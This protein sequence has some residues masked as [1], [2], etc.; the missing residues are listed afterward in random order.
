MYTPG[1][2]R[3]ISNSNLST[4]AAPDSK[5]FLMQTG[6][7]ENISLTPQK[8]SQP[9]IPTN[10]LA[11][12]F[13]FLMGCTVFAYLLWVRLESN[14]ILSDSIQHVQPFHSRC[15]INEAELILLN[16]STTSLNIPRC[17]DGSSPAYYIRRGFEDGETKWIIHFEGGG[18]CYDME[19]IIRC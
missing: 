12:L 8:I 3:R 10:F 14:S 11:Y 13:C 19:V 16:N 7:E 6:D 1:R 18:W 15:G 5:G 2:I 9:K 4:L 17:L